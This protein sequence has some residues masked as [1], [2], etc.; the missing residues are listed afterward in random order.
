MA[1]SSWSE[2]SSP[3]VNLEFGAINSSPNYYTTTNVDYNRKSYHVFV[4]IELIVLISLASKVSDLELRLDSSEAEIAELK[5]QQQS[6]SEPPN[7]DPV[8]PGNDHDDGDEG[9]IAELEQSVGKMKDNITVIKDELALLDE[10]VIA[11]QSNLISLRNNVDSNTDDIK[12]MEAEVTQLKANLTRVD[13]NAANPTSDLDSFKISV[14]DQFSKLDAEIAVLNSTISANL[15]RFFE[16]SRN[17]S[18]V[19]TDLNTVEGKV[20]Q[21]ESADFGSQIRNISDKQTDQ[22][23]KITDLV[24]R[25]EIIEKMVPGVIEANLL[26]KMGVENPTQYITCNG[27]IVIQQRVDNTNFDLTL[28]DYK[29]AFGNPPDGSFW[30]GLDVLYGLT[31]NISYSW[32]LRIE[33]DISGA[34]KIAEYSNF[35]IGPGDTYQLLIGQE[36]NSQIGSLFKTLMDGENFYAGAGSTCSG[37]TRYKSG[38]WLT[39]GAFCGDINLNA[40]FQPCGSNFCA[41]V[42]SNQYVQKTKMMIKLT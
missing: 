3:G 2:M 13:E 28:N 10:T 8:D 23:E 21:L 15:Q 27:Y 41:R 37:S 39:T 11:I 20:D 42:D 6:G 29:D 5:S 35:A 30:L 25:F 31:K 32:T 22:E 38:W 40:P 4:L 33:V 24:D 9:S 36:L 1:S 19:G 7:V 26:R 18:S 17:I 16:L 12:L 14:E 34:T